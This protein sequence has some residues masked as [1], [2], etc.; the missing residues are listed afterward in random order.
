MLDDE[1][2]FADIVKT[3]DNV[4]PKEDALQEYKELLISMSN[5]ERESSTSSLSK[6]YNRILVGWK[7][8]AKTTSR[9]RL[10]WPGSECFGRRCA[11][12]RK[13]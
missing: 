7:G 2:D 8:M 5:M 3:Y 10:R 9:R 12:A 4:A 11:T 6:L 1:R 13:S